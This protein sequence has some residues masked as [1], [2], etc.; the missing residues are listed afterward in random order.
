[1]VVELHFEP[2]LVENYIHHPAVKQTC[3]ASTT[4]NI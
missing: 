4:G 2:V 1:M 3:L